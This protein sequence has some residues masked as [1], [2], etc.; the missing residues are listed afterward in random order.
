MNNKLNIGELKYLMPDYISGLLSDN[1]KLII[2]NALK[3]SAELREFYEDV[4]GTFE[5][6]KNVKF[7]EPP[8][9]YFNTLLPKI[10]EKIEQRA[11]R[12]FQWSNIGAMWKIIIPVAAVLLIFIFYMV[13][14][15]P[16][17]QL[18]KKE[19]K[20]IEEIKKDTPKSQTPEIKD[21]KKNIIEPKT[22]NISDEKR[23]KI[24]TQQQ[25]KK[26]YTPQYRDK[27]FE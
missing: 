6:V 10:H 3:S 27:E 13:L 26:N 11:S 4:K 16:E 23:V 21:E 12:K 2:E 22:D 8:A 7:E 9:L 15:S 14:K 20:P 1:D 24:K 17:D 18:T 25:T 19:I 5:F